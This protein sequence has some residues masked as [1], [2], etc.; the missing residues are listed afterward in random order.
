MLDAMGGTL[1]AA[2]CE[3]MARAGAG[4]P[5]SRMLSS[6]RSR[7]MIWGLRSCRYARPCATC[8]AHRSASAC[9]Y[10]TCALQSKGSCYH[11]AHRQAVVLQAFHV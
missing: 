2:A 4:S 7:W 10:S 6:F 3:N 5:P 8:V 9:V 1:L 11:D